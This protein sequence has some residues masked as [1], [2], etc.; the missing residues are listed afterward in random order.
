MRIS[1]LFLLLSIFMLLT[2]SDFVHLVK[3]ADHIY[4]VSEEIVDPS[5]IDRRIGE[6]TEYAEEIKDASSDQASN[7][8]PPGTDIYKIDDIPIEQ[9][10]AIEF[11]GQF[12]KAVNQNNLV[13]K[14]KLLY[15]YIVPAVF[16]TVLTVSYL[17]RERMKKTY[18]RS[19][20]P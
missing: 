4:Q 10:L 17:L 11:E 9:A 13:T 15:N 20:L 6:I 8:Y 2:V 16:L 7:F 5:S 1:I 3:Y 18:H 19:L 12:L 14:E